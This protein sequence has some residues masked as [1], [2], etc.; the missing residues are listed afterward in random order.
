M[1][2]ENK[3]NAE[4]AARL[5]RQAKGQGRAA[6]RN[7]TK[8]AKVVADPVV[9]AASEELQDT[10]HKLE[11]T[12]EDA[13]MGARRLNPRVLSRIS[14]DTGQAFIAMAVAIWAGTIAGNKFRAAAAGR[15]A[16]MTRPID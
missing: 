10:A 12:V 15:K 11:G 14:G 8:A 13:V 16:L 4:E 6:A 9:E 7:A 5:A 3:K 2:D 1:N